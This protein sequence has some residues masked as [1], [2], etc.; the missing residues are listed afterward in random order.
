MH[1]MSGRNR[2]TASPRRP[3]LVGRSAIVSESP[4]RELEVESRGVQEW[5]SA[6]NCITGA[7]IDARHS[8][9]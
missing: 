7:L 8:L 6:E 2:T 9:H 3:P 5:L 1:P 4:T